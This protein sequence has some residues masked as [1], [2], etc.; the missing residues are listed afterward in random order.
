M[1]VVIILIVVVAGGVGVC[2]GV[3]SRCPANFASP[4][5]DIQLRAV[6]VRDVKAHDLNK[7]GL[8]DSGGEVAQGAAIAAIIHGR[9]T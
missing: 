9:N 1:I 2:A 7:K 8:D 6:G 5:G 3:S 4:A